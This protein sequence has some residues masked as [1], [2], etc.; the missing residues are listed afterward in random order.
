M[1]ASWVRNIIADCRKLGVAPF[2][3][4][5]GSYQNNPFVTEEGWDVKH[6][7]L[8][9]VH[10]KGGCMLDGKLVR[11]FPQRRVREVEEATAA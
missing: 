4:Q 10:G 3:K 1:K 11:E 6:A 5:W 2:F 7:R 8:E 9:D